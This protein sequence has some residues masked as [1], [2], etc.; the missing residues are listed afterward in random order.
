MRP[1]TP[2]PYKCDSVIGSFGK[3]VRAMGEQPRQIPTAAERHTPPA[4]DL[5][6]SP[7]R[8]EEQCRRSFFLPTKPALEELRRS[9][10]AEGQPPQTQP[11]PPPAQQATGKNA[12]Q[13]DPQTRPISP[14]VQLML[15]N[16]Y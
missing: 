9:V 16:D 11:Q 8:V 6:W 5:P 14:M 13:P 2:F 10:P 7:K 1:I 12:P 4:K 15:R 3:T